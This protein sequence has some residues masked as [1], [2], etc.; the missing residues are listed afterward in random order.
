MRRYYKSGGKICPKGK[1][2]AKRKFDTYPSAYANMYASQVCKGK[3]TPGG[4]KGK[5]KSQNMA[6]PNAK[7]KKVKKVISKLK[8]ASKAHAGQAKTLQKVLKA[9]RRKA[10]GR[11]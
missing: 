8:K 9:P 1:A 3:I 2:A 4:K 6:L 10:N 11:S 5:K 7:K